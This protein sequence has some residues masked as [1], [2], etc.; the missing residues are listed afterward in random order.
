MDFAKNLRARIADLGLTYAE[1]ARRSHLEVRR[2]HH[3][4]VGDRQPDLQTLVRLA[5]VLETTPDI[6][7]GV[8]QESSIGPDEATRLRA[9]LS[10]TARTMDVVALRLLMSLANGVM[11]FLR[12]G[13]EAGGI[14]GRQPKTARRPTKSE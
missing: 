2:F 3:Y 14:R 4:T 7:L 1:V 5:E 10:A 8:R 12:D 13:A 6:L 11:A 9:Q